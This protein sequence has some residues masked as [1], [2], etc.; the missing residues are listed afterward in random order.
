MILNLELGRLSQQDCES[1]AS[2]SYTNGNEFLFHRLSHIESLWGSVASVSKSFPRSSSTWSPCH[3]PWA[4]YHT[5]PTRRRK[6]VLVEQTHTSAYVIQ[7][8]L[9]EQEIQEPYKRQTGKLPTGQNS[10]MF[11]LKAF[12]YLRNLRNCNWGQYIQ[13]PENIMGSERT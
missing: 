11:M 12:I 10:K 1:V 4:S 5:P 7:Q 2:L 3:L 8:I 6:A 13:L 9:G